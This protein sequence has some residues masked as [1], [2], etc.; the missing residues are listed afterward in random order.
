VAFQ[1]ILK[2][3]ILSTS[4]ALGAIFADF[5]GEAVEVV[6]ERPFDA[7]DHD[8]RVVGA[9]Q[10]IAMMRLKELCTKTRI[11]TPQRFGIDFTTVHVLSCDLKDGYYIVLI[12][13]PTANE[14][15]AWRQL[16]KCRDELLAEI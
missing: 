10:G 12:L 2:R 4:G 13:D 16:E 8:L 3:L 15:L 6:T 5:E 1:R 7:G 14:G 9:Y 11:G